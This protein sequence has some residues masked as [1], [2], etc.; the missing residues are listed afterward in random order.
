[1][2]CIAAHTLDQWSSVCWLR[3]TT[4][5]CANSYLFP[6]THPACL[7]SP[8]C[9]LW[10]DLHSTGSSSRA[11]GK[12]AGAYSWCEG[13][14]NWTSRVGQQILPGGSLPDAAGVGWERV[15]CGRRRATRWNAAPAI[16]AGVVRQTETDAPGTG[17]RGAW[18]KV[19]HSVVLPTR[20]KWNKMLI[21]PS[22]ILFRDYTK[23]HGAT[24]KAAANQHHWT[25]YLSC[26]SSTDRTWS[27]Y[28]RQ[29]SKCSRRDSHWKWNLALKSSTLS[30]VYNC[31]YIFF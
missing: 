4:T 28:E 5:Y 17:G 15:T 21:K 3:H 1:M 9:S 7:L 19:W 12:A 27:N 24:I 26:A 11:A 18:D 8:L 22:I 14:R 13:Y 20:A 10:P 30:N 25:L 29:R 16:V 6:S 2:L 23:R 31:K